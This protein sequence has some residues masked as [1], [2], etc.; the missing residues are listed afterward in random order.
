MKTFHILRG[1]TGQSR[2]DVVR[3]AQDS[4][5]LLQDAVYLSAPQKVRTYA[6]LEDVRGRGVQTTAEVVD[7]RR[8]I[9]LITE[10]DR[11]VVW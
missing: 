4:I 3:P 1:A 8:I 6:C 11:V 9:Q 2:P 7:Y 10:H 5:L